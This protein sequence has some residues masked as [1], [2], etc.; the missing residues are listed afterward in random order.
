M[1]FYS[2]ALLALALVSLFSFA[3]T[4]VFAQGGGPAGIPLIE[5]MFARVVCVTVPL[6]YTALL[7]VLVIAGI[8]Y[9]TSGGEAKAVAS[10]HQTVTWGLLGVL[11]LAIAWLI[12][13]LIKTNSMKA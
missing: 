8:K 12:L 11:F 13:L 5:Y 1:P 6:G 3:T 4:S 10:A 2:K 9:L 7:V